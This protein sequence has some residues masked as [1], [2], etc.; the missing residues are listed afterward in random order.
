M[1]S[2]TDMG[3]QWLIPPPPPAP[4][5]VSIYALAAMAHLWRPISKF[6]LEHP[7]HTEVLDPA[8]VLS[9][10]GTD[11]TVP[12]TRTSHHIDVAVAP[13]VLHARAYT[14]R[15]AD[16]LKIRATAGLFDY[17][18][19]SVY[20]LQERTP[21]GLVAKLL[22]VSRPAGR[23]KQKIS[24][25]GYTLGDRLAGYTLGDRLHG[26]PLWVDRETDEERRVLGFEGAA[27]A[28]LSYNGGLLAL[29]PDRAVVSYYA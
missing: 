25:A 26:G 10:A 18:M 1:F 27:H 21:G 29:Y 23:G 11:A 24:V 8:I 3:R 12:G 15:V 7:V 5:S 2:D 20:R 9:V 6:N 13:D 14:L 16:R 28:E 17:T 22:A 4:G 19:I